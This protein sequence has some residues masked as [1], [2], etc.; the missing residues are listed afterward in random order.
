[1]TQNQKTTTIS[2]NQKVTQ[3]SSTWVNRIDFLL[4]ILCCVL[5]AGRCMIFESFPR[6]RRWGIPPTR[7]DIGGAEVTAMTVFAALIITLAFIWLILRL[8]ASSFTWR[9]TSLAIPLFLFALGSGISYM[10]ASNRHTARIEIW[11]LLSVILLGILL[12]QLL[13]APWKRNFLLCVLAATGVVMGH[14]CWEQNSHELTEVKKAYLED[15][16]Q[17]LLKQNIQPGTYAAQQYANRVFSR[18]IRGYFGVSNSAAAFFI[19]SIM[20]TTALI[21]DHTQKKY[22]SRDWH[23]LLAG[24]LLLLIQI[25]G[26]WLTRSKGGIVSFLAATC[27]TAILWLLRKPLQRHWR[28]VIGVGIVLTI[29]AVVAATAHGIYHDRLPTNSM[30][31]RWQYWKAAADMIADDNHWLTGVG[32]KNFGDY[33]L[34]YMN[35]AAP[36]QVKDPHCLP[37]SLWSQWGIFSLLALVWAVI[38]ITIRLARP[39]AKTQTPN[40]IPDKNMNSNA[41]IIASST[42]QTTTTEP[43]KLWVYGILISVGIM[44]LRLAVSD[45][46]GC[47]SSTERYSVLAISFM[48]PSAIWLVAFVILLALTRTTNLAAEYPSDTANTHS[49]LVILILGCGLIG[50]LLHNCIDFGFFRPGV[51]GI[52]FACIAIAVSSRPQRPPD[53]SNGKYLKL[54]LAALLL[55][56]AT[57]CYLWFYVAL[58]VAKSQRYLD[59]ALA[60]PTEA[61][62]CLEKAQQQNP[63]DP[64]IKFLLGT[65]KLQQWYAAGRTQPQLLQEAV[66]DLLVNERTPADY[67]HPLMQSVMCRLA[68]LQDIQI[69]KDLTYLGYKKLLLEIFARAQADKTKLHIEYARRAI[70]Y[71]EKALER[72]PNDSYLLIY[73]ADLLTFL[74]PAI[75]RDHAHE[76]AAQVLKKALDNEQAFLEQQK[77]MYPECPQPMYRLEPQKI[78]QAVVL[79]KFI[80]QKSDPLKPK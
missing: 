75:G 27:L 49:S 20:A 47:G 67:S 6:A 58:P 40:E 8:K 79:Q 44:L 46:S 18:D 72:N 66:A 14:R 80:Q 68:A 69:T 29:T 19:L 74:A 30:W 60:Q 65:Y 71:A 13:N 4:L 3:A 56:A 63:E 64:E 59:Q 45:L 42:T 53:I 50:F 37:I 26:L 15:P 36:E 43:K 24:A 9:K 73:Y 10:A 25:V 17:A 41:N 52:C 77:E 39:C 70:E 33:Y 55:S 51:A 34:R 35:P 12:I 62:T 38:A 76:Q 32:P 22:L 1:M 54:T 2:E 31:V 57:V 48:I 5:L 23:F 61:L 16:N 78:M 28:K 11:N 7:I 21:L